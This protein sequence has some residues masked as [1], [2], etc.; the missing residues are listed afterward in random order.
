MFAT[1]DYL[2]IEKE[3]WQHALFKKNNILWLQAKIVVTLEEH[4]GLLLRVFTG[5]DVPTFR[6]QKH[7]IGLSVLPH[8]HMHARTCVYLTIA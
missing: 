2:S 8:A 6:T 5:H 3:A 1:E 4:F 7:A